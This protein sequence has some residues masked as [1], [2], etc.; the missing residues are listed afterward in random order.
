MTAISNES[1]PKSNVKTK[2]AC[3]SSKELAHASRKSGARGYV[4]KA[5]RSTQ[6]RAVSASVK[7][8]SNPGTNTTLVKTALGLTTGKFLHGG[9]ATLS[10]N[11]EY[12]FECSDFEYLSKKYSLLFS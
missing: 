7:L 3:T 1:Q 8:P 11:L 6:S 12:Y 9:Q 5:C 2:E 10:E 4:M